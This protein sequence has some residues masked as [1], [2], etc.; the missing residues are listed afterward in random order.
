MTAASTNS[1]GPSVL[2]IDDSPVMRAFI[3]RVLS[4]SGMA[5]GRVLE[6]SDGQQALEILRREHV[7]LALADINMPNMDGAELMRQVAADPV[8]RRIPVIVVSTDASPRRTRAMLDLGVAAYVQKP[9]PPESLRAELEQV[10][11]GR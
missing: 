5:I 10:L 11:K 3:R 6:A 9:F 4:I 2:I 1:N 8:L 7:D